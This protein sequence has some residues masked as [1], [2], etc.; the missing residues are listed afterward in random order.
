[1][2]SLQCPSLAAFCKIS[3]SILLVSS[4]LLIKPKK[5][6]L[7]EIKRQKMNGTF[8]WDSGDG[9]FG[10][11]T[12]KMTPE[13]ALDLKVLSMR[14][15]LDPKRFYKNTKPDEDEPKFFQVGT[16]IDSPADFYSSRIPMKMRKKTFVDELLADQSFRAYTKRKYGELQAKEAALRGGSHRANKKKNKNRRSDSNSGRNNN[17]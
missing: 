10:M 9:W 5:K 3:R 2:M 1:M 16:V 8:R 6:K 11:K 17:R 7:N 4:S 14:N 12:A 13:L 15:Y